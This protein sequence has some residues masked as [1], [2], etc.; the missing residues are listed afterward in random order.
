MM[1]IGL[2]VFAL[3]QREILRFVR[4]RSRLIGA[5]AQPL[6]FWLLL[7]GGFSASFRPPGAPE[8]SG[9]FEYLY[10]GIIMLTLL[11]TAIFS[12]IAVI[13]D[14]KIGFLQG[15]LVAP[16]SRI[17]IVL[18]QAL[19]STTLALL[20]GGFLLLLAPVA[21]VSLSWEGVCA[22]LGVMLLVGLALSSLGLIIA[23]RMESVQGFHAIMNLILMPT[24]FLSGAFFPATG[25]PRWLSWVMSVNPLTYGMAALRRCLYVGDPVA[26]SQLPQLMPSLL[27]TLVFAVGTFWGAT[28]TAKRHFLQ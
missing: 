18:G 3:W 19:G 16:V 10:P 5:F 23:W 26:V 24:W 8:G 1:K 25:L 21:G 20:Q 22:A 6:V 14:R 2:A 4:Q 9:Y 11:F 17:S 13:E 7:G 27:I 12:T 28:H 15:V